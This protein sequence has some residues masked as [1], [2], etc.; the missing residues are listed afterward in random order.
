M[1]FARETEFDPLVFANATKYGVP[2]WV[3]KATI[4][5]ESSF[6]PRA[7]RAELLHVP[8]DASR[9]LMQIL[10]TTARDLGLRGTSGDDMTKTGGL[11]EPAL[12]IQ[13][14]TKYLGQLHSRNPSEPWDNIYAAYNAGSIRRT[15]AGVLV[16]ERNVAGWRALASYFNPTWDASGGDPFR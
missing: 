5:K 4:G 16:N 10:E 9:G 8:P 13:L 3:I 1:R 7:Y 14:G 15:D 6:D 11:Y 2:A 12:S